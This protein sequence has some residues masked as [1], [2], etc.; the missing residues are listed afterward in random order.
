MKKVKTGL[1]SVRLYFPM[2]EKGYADYIKA[3]QK[4]NGYYAE[5]FVNNEYCIEVTKRNLSV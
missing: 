1:F 5:I 3:K 4:Y 2:N